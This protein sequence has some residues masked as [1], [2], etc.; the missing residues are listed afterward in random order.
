M[1]FKI[2]HTNSAGCVIN[3]DD[4]DEASRPFEHEGDTNDKLLHYVR[5]SDVYA[6]DTLSIVEV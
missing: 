6:G 3:D 5:T 1:A 4:T 2:V